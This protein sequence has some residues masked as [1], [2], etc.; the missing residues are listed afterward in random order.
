MDLRSRVMV[1]T[2]VITASGVGTGGAILPPHWVKASPKQQGAA[3]DWGIVRADLC[4]AVRLLQQIK[5]KGY[6]HRGAAGFIDSKFNSTTAA[7]DN[8]SP[9]SNPFI[10]FNY[11]IIYFSLTQKYA[12]HQ[13]QRNYY[14]FSIYEHFHFYYL[15]FLFIYSFF[16]VKFKS[17]KY[18]IQL[19]YYLNP[20]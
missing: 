2:G 10:P 8:L 5:T 7:A 3:I 17:I 1:T 16:Y 9:G 20:F 6:T 18:F 19:K 11:F 12:A 15:E 14:L 4:A 13:N